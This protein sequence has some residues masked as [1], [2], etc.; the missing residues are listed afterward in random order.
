MIRNIKDLH[1]KKLA[2]SDGDIGHVSDFYFDDMT[3]A[4]RYLVANTDALMDGRRVLLSPH[5][6]GKLVKTGDVLTVNLT[7]E[8]IKNSPSFNSHIPVSR[9]YE[10]EYYQYYGW[11]SYWIGGGMWGISDMPVAAMLEVPETTHHHGHQQR[12]DVHLRSTNAMDGY[13]IQATDG[14]IGTVID[15]VMDDESWVI[16]ELIVETGHW[17]AGKKIFIASSKIERISY[18]DSKV[19]VNL[20]QEEIRQTTENQ[21]AETAA[22]NH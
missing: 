14:P 12:E 21:V 4:V 17:Y 11:P 13:H 19:F 6:F 20:T 2:A 22:K 1:D 9:Q 3:W 15:F 5:A 16:R 8:Q 18:D 10:E 7:C